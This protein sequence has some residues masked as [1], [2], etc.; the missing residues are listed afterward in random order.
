LTNVLIEY[1]FDLFNKKQMSDLE[2]KNYFL[3]EENRQLKSELKALKKKLRRQETEHSLYARSQNRQLRKLEKKYDK[4]KTDVRK[5][6]ST[7][8][9]KLASTRRDLVDSKQYV[10][11]LI[12]KYRRGERIGAPS[13]RKRLPALTSGNKDEIK[14]IE[15][16]EIQE[17]DNI[18]KFDKAVDQVQ[19]S[20]DEAVAQLNSVVA[21]EPILTIEQRIKTYYEQGSWC[22]Y[23]LL[24]NNCVLYYALEEKCVVFT[25]NPLTSDNAYFKIIGYIRDDVSIVD[26]KLKELSELPLSTLEKMEPDDKE[27]TFDVGEK[28]TKSSLPE[29]VSPKSKG[30]RQKLNVDIPPSRPNPIASNSSLV[31]P[32]SKAYQQKLI[33]NSNSVTSPRGKDKTP[34]KKPPV[35][36]PVD[37][38]VQFEVER[39]KANAQDVIRFSAR[40]KSVVYLKKLQWMKFGEDDVEQNVTEKRIN[41]LKIQYKAIFTD[42]FGFDFEP[43]PEMDEYQTETQFIAK[44]KRYFSKRCSGVITD[45]TDDY[46]NY[47]K[48]FKSIKEWKRGDI[49]FKLSNN[50][51]IIVLL[52]GLEVYPCVLQGLDDKWIKYLQT[53]LDEFEEVKE[54]R[55]DVITTEQSV[56]DESMDKFKERNKAVGEELSPPSEATRQDERETTEQG[57][58]ESSTK[59]EELESLPK[60]ISTERKRDDDIEIIDNYPQSEMERI[61]QANKKRFIEWEW[62]GNKFRYDALTDILKMNDK[63]YSKTGWKTTAWDEADLI[64]LGY[65]KEKKSSSTTLKDYE[66]RKNRSC[67]WMN[68]GD[69]YEYDGA[70]DIL[71]LNSA[72]VQKP[73]GEQGDWSESDLN[74]YKQQEPGKKDNLFQHTTATVLPKRD[75]NRINKEKELDIN[76]LPTI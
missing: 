63:I 60:T 34:N 3:K 42:K 1:C 24:E 14:L 27:L 18:E 71:W 6:T 57:E 28:S 7:L 73:L 38:N 74:K 20:M 13:S 49:S 68:G 10:K 75:R 72:R 19:Y 12:E 30:G 69:K 26:A 21:D 58:K 40:N 16:Q 70:R 66:E 44:Y 65:T 29:I 25:T 11:D 5:E 46:R 43:I 52:A 45:G 55:P 50:D 61:D 15:K 33:A 48:N 8:Q 17:N 54:S 23:V 31:S 32:K 4:I 56:I 62:T 9:A 41:S 67:T 35:N 36:V 22:K 53:H 51:D 2:D 59:Q 76:A 37:N 47:I 39:K 64:Q